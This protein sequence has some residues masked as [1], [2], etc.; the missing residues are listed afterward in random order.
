MATRNRTPL[1]RKYRDALRSV[2]VPSVSSPPSQSGPSTSSSGNGPVTE[3]VSASLLNRNRHYAPLS[4]DDPGSS[5]RGA[6]TVGLPPAWVDVSEEIAVDI[7]RAR[8]KMS[9]LVKAHAKALMPS[10]GDGK[11]EQHAI[12]TLTQEITHLLRRSEKRLKKLSLSGTSEDLNV[13]KNVQ[14]S[15]A[16]DLQSLS[17][18]L[19]KKQSTYLKRL[20]QQK[21]EG[22][23]GI[24]LEMK[25]DGKKSRFDDD[26]DDFVNVGFSDHQMSQVKKS[27]ALT[28]E[29][30]KEIAQVV[31]SVNDLAQIMKDLS[32]LVIDQ[33]TIIDRIDYNVQNV[34]ASVEEGF[35]QLQKAE[36]TQKKGGM[37]MCA[38]VLVIMCFVMLVLLILKAILF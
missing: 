22:Q 20:R 7:Q 35:K 8:T 9:E 32:V 3:L 30:E 31:E 18:E 6:L 19:R 37:V 23:D 12:E 15:L 28:R 27:E 16:T 36:R 33:G 34:A 25:L 4:T 17:V 5:S 38:T 1:F 21:E 26:D 24:D 29:R 2:R 13:Q 10:F 11:E 14:R